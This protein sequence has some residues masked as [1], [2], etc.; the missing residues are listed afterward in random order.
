MFLKKLTGCKTN[1]LFFI[2]LLINITF[3]LLL[4]LINIDFGDSG[5]EEYPDYVKFL[6]VVALAPVIE[7]VLFN[8]LPIKILQYVNFFKKNPLYVIFIASVVFSLTHT[9]S[10]AYVFMTYIGAITLNT[11]FIVVQIKKNT[12]IAFIL[13]V[14]LHSAYNL[15]G[16]LLIE[17]FDL[18]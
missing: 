14:L 7:T 3:S 16:F 10:I 11:F 2:I 5:L 4:K 13:T 12:K 6:F 9:Y 15:I 8:L 1:F 17:V 18:L